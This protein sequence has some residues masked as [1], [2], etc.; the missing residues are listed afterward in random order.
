MAC[1]GSCSSRGIEA[2]GHEG[3]M[4]KRW[5]QRGSWVTSVRGDEKVG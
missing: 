2:K 3:E 1:S 5:R 4:T